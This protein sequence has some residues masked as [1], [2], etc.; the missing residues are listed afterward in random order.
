MVGDILL[1][2]GYQKVVGDWNIYSAIIIC[3]SEEIT[4]IPP[5]VA[6]PLIARKYF[7]WEMFI[8]VRYI[9]LDDI[10]MCRTFL[11]Q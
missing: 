10:A 6:K 5:F 1:T 3:E 4:A 7:Y 2:I 11:F 9:S 8:K